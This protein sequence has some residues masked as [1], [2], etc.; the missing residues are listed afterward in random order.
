VEE[1]R[2]HRPSLPRTDQGA[3]HLAVVVIMP[4]EAHH[5]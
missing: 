2:P 5:V 3:G 1:P 4:S